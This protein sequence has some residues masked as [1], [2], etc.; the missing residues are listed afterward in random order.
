MNTLSKIAFAYALAFAST[1]FA[2]AEEPAPCAKDPAAN[3]LPQRMA[4]MNEQMDRIE[5]TTD[6]AEQRRLMELHMKSMHEGM[7]EVR[8]RH[9][10]AE[11]RMDMMQA[12]MEQ[13]MRHELAAQD[14]DGR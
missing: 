5:W 12:M 8:R 7:R 9:T 10:T 2:A 13:M 14:G 11:C 3:G 1:A 6:R 4:R